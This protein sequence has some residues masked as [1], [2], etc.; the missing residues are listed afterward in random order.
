MEQGKELVVFY[1]LSGNTKLMAEEIARCTGGDLLQLK[2]KNSNIKPN[3]FMKFIW[4][5]KQVKVGS[6]PE[7]MPYE[8]DFDKYDTI[9]FG[10]P[11]WAS[12]YV[13]VL[14]TFFSEQV[15]KD[16]NI[17]MFCCHGG[18]GNGK[19]FNKMKELLEGNQFIGEIELKDPQ[20]K[21]LE[22][23]CERLRT[24]IKDVL[25]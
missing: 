8:V 11:I 24:W 22:I 20:K 10:T 25:A 17:A 21:G 3:G 7:L 16:K 23:A 19:A 12:R 2:P 6:K 14:H 1:S 13:P 5:G 15:I 4:G 18:G 9:I